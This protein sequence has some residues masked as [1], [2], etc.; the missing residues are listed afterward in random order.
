MPLLLTTRRFLD[1]HA[2]RLQAACTE[3]GLAL[4]P[5]AVP[6][7]DGARLE[8]AELARIEVAALMDPFE[9]NEG[10]AR[11]FFGA[12]LRAPA[13][14]WVHVPFAGVDHPVFVHLR[15]RNI[16]LSTSSGATAEPIA[17]TA[18]GGVLALARGFPHWWAAQQRREWAPHRGARIPDD[19]RGQTMVVLGM[20]AIGGHVARLARAL[21][22]YVIGVRRNPPTADDHVDEMHPPARLAEL[23]PRADWLVIACPLTAETRG[24]VDDAALARLRPTAHL[25]NVAR[26]QIVD[27]AALT[28]AL[29][30]GRLAGAYL[31][32]FEEEPL[33]AGS[34]LWS[35]PNVIVSPHNSAASTGNAARVVE[36]FLRNL[37]HWGRDEPL[38]NEVR[39]P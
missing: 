32:V 21:G 29:A 23:L 10:L 39:E 15:E 31:D 4:D 12:V 19:L 26:G 38:E 3:A 24:L 6:E 28:A 1:R 27:E 11:R 5:V 9:G 16:R 20:G 30:A 8:E 36:I 35:L 17:H 22:L 13:V 18:I 25:V 33:P 14:R 34:P 7:G 37:A 2:D